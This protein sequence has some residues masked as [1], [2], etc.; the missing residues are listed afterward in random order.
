MPINLTNYTEAKEGDKGIAMG[1]L[2]DDTWEMPEQIA[3]LEK[4]LKKNKEKIKKGTTLQILAS[5]KGGC[6]R[7]WSSYNY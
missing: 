5:A 2:C 3:T 7:R 1:H 6:F 4:W